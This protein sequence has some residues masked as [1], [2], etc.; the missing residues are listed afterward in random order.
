VEI[1][2]KPPGK[3]H[4]SIN[5]LSG[6]ERTLVALAFLYALYSVRPAP[7]VVL[8][9][10]DAALDEPNTLRFV[11]LLK[12]MAL[13][14]QVIVVTHNKLTMEAADVL[15]GV[16]MEIP[17]VSKIIGVSFESLLSV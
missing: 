10:V 16:T 5:L 9:E 13:E 15:Y 1:E 17:G 8:D 14:T 12:Q 11:E 6:G 3:K 7:F 2:A 4:S